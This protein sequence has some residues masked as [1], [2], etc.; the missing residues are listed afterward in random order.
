MSQFFVNLKFCIKK[1]TFFFIKMLFTLSWIYHIVLIKLEIEIKGI[2][3]GLIS[4]KSFKISMKCK[5]VQ[6][7]LIFRLNHVFWRRFGQRLHPI[8]RQFVNLI[9]HNTI[10]WYCRWNMSNRMLSEEKSKINW[11]MLMSSQ[12]IA[13]LLY[14]VMSKCGCP[15][16]AYS[17]F[18]Q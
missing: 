8:F 9:N 2:R 17:N 3:S 18:Y 6:L 4:I 7:I 12:D 5:K 16:S 11:S 13:L 15:V 1:R 14:S 10:Q